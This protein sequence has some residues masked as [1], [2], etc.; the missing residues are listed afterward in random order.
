MH[1]GG[2]LR[3]SE[4]EPSHY[5]KRRRLFKARDLPQRLDAPLAAEGSRPSVVTQVQQAQKAR[6]SFTLTSHCL[7][8]CKSVE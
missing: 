5:P 7:N 1:P 6:S 2:P 8:I 4:G 3:S